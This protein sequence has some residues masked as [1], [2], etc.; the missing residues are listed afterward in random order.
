[1]TNILFVCRYNRYRSRVAEALFNFYNKNRDIKVKSAGTDSLELG[2][3]IIGIAGQVL[4]ELKVDFNKNQRSRAIN[5]SL[6]DWADKIYV[7]ADDVSLEGLPRAKTKQIDI[8]DSWQTY[9]I[10]LEN[11]KE[12]E[13]H[14]KQIIKEMNI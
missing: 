6:I 3:P 9:E 14:V 12:I 1:M 5:K 4:T 7:V 10:A 8:P 11:I 13:G 2:L